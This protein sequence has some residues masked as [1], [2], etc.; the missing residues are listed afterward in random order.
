MS[1]KEHQNYGLV[2]GSACRAYCFTVWFE[3]R[4]V[5]V[6]D[7]NKQIKE[8]YWC[9]GVDFEALKERLTDY[10]DSSS[11]VRYVCC[12][13]ERCPSENSGLLHGHIS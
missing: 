6:L 5:D 3:G 11:N 7:D 12:S 13:Q 8:S 10:F 9:E 1:K 4:Q 2:S